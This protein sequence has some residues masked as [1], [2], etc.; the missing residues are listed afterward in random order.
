VIEHI[1]DAVFIAD[2]ATKRVVRV[3][4]AVTRLLGFDESLQ[5][6]VGLEHYSALIQ[7]QLPD[8]TPLVTEQLLVMRALQGEEVHNAHVV[9]RRR[10]GELIHV[11]AGASPIRN[12]SG[13]IVLAVVTAHEVTSLLQIQAELE[14]SNQA[15]DMFLAMLSHELRTPLTPVLGWANI[16]RD[17]LDD[18]AVVKRGLE[19][20]ERNARLQ[21]QL[22]DDL[23]DLSRII[24]G[25]IELVRAPVDLNQIVRHALETVQYRLDAQML[26]LELD[27]ALDPLPVN[28]DATRL[29][30]VIW[31]L[32]SNAVKFTPARGRISVSSR[33]AGDYCQVEV[34]DNGVGI[35]TGLLQVIFNRFCQADSGTSRRHGGLGIGLAIA[36]SL[37]EMH[38]G[39][40][41]AESKGEGRGARF[42]VAIPLH[43]VKLKRPAR[44]RR[45]RDVAA[46]NL[47]D[48]RV[49]ILEDSTD[50]RE[51]LGIILNAY[52]CQVSLASSVPEGLRLAA[53]IMPDVVISDIGLPDLDGYEFVQQLRQLRGLRD[54][55][56]IALTGYAMEGDRKRALE[57]GFNKHL[58][59]P[60]ETEHLIAA[61]QQVLTK[62]NT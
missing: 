35:K 27:L 54:I 49:L 61:I 40:I 33:L 2:A 47:E 46:T 5:L 36:R 37:V 18:R 62:L 58:P 48:V 16:L 38:G 4:S 51:L 13:E 28:A 12:T 60:V 41:E 30:Q 57:S 14:R 32:L 1:T 56:V 19:A 25:K 8:G 59:K 21:A 34:S 52:G 24:T 53:E 10:D 3:N 31:N 22:V 42:T 20:I 6:E 50:T 7:P 45:R 11:I 23:L 55:P 9:W 15:K 26:D 44:Q 43:E 39:W 17:N 29:E